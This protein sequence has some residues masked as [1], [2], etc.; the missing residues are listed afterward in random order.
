MQSNLQNFYIKVFALFVIFLCVYPL[1]IIARISTFSHI[2]EKDYGPQSQPRVSD[3]KTYNDIIAVRIVRNQVRTKGRHCNYNIFF[4]RIIYPNGTVIEKDIKLE[5]VQPFN[6]CSYM[7]GNQ[8]QL[9]YEI[10][11]MNRILVIYNNSTNSQ[12]FEGWGM[13]TDFDGN[14]FDRTSIGLMGHRN[15]RNRNRLVK[16]PLQVVFNIN[17]EKGFIIGHRSLNNDYFAWRQYKMGLDGK[18]IILTSGNITIDDSFI[19]RPRSLVQTADENY[20]FIYKK[21]ASPN[22][23]LQDQIIAEFIGYNKSDTT[24]I[25]LYQTNLTNRISHPISCNIEYTRVGHSCSFPMKFNN[26]NFNVK[27]GF[28]SSGAAISLNY[29]EFSFPNNQINF[30]S[31]RLQSL[32]FGGYILTK[33]LGNDSTNDNGLY[34]YVFSEDGTPYNTPGLNQLLNANLNYAYTPLPNNTFLIAQMEHNNT[35]ILN[36][37]DLPKITNDSGYFN[38]NVESTFPAINSLI[39]STYPDIKNISIDFRDPVTLSDGNLTIYKI[40]QGKIL[41]QITPGTG[42]T[43]D[44]DNTRVILNIFNYTFGKSGGNY[45]ITIDN[46]FVKSRI[47]GEPLLGVRYGI[48]N[49]EI[50]DK[51]YMYTITSPT[52][53]LFRLTVD[54]TN[55]IKNS[56]VDENNQFFNNLLDELAEALQISRNRLSKNSKNQIDPDSGDKLLISINIDETKNP[57]EKDVNSVIQD[58]NTMMSD[59]SQTPIGNGTLANLDFTYGFNPA[60]NYLQEYGP[61]LLCLL[62]IIVLLVILYILANRREKK[63]HNI[64][65]FKFSLYVFDFVMDTLFIINNANDVIKLYI[66]SM[67]FYTIPLGLN[68]ALAFLI[69][70]K[71]NRRKEFLLWFTENNKLTSIFTILAGINIEM[72]SILH[73]NF[74]GFSNFQAPFS[75]Y[76]KSAIFW[77]AVSNIFIEDIPQFVIQV[78]FRTRSI[79]YDFIPIFTLVSSAITL[80]INII[81]HLY[82]SINYI[83]NKSLRTV[84]TSEP[85][86]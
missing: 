65:I 32:L 75:D 76:A 21:Y 13:I 2:E 51:K 45:S 27:I 85:N 48:W 52:S 44:N 30:S 35:W 42:C 15:H 43:L 53:G 34:I 69:I 11:E 81:S 74:A 23:I 19:F 82:Q 72:L 1:H 4:L 29:T 24:K 37:I 22:S 33:P 26:S 83:R 79:S 41:R 38:T 16:P 31:W 18:F 63:G 71:E 78:L 60:P 58:I 68:M 70:A 77:I 12:T 36:L 62:L 6:Y 47:Y 59:S 66:P 5:G 50:E 46:N 61:K 55:I 49:F 84:P 73:S 40:D 56:A 64:A 8:D 20:Y 28:L 39:P 57:Y 10:I 9:Y 80:G 17:K 86:D 3:I 67:V 14:V 54:R 7:A 25:Y